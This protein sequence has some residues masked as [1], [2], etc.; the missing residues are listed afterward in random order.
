VAELKI[1]P[2]TNFGSNTWI[3]SD[4][5]GDDNDY[6]NSDTMMVVMVVAAVAGAVEVAENVKIDLTKPWIK[7]FLLKKSHLF[8]EV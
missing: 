7:S 3:S 6:G 1:L 5:V 8:V 4:S 2:E